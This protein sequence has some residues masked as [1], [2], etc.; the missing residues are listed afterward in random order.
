MPELV[1]HYI[2]NTEFLFRVIT[3]REDAKT[4]TVRAPSLLS[5][6]VQRT[7]L[8]LLIT[9]ILGSSADLSTPQPIYTSS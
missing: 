2:H 9:T 5:L 3:P 4:I 7:A 8:T 6:Y 1:R